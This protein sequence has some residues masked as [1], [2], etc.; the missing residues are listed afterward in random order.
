MISV[1][2]KQLIIQT[3]GI[4]LHVYEY[5]RIPKLITN[6]DEFFYRQQQKLEATVM[7]NG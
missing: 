2:I 1:P 6:I 3:T 5:L 7:N 4:T